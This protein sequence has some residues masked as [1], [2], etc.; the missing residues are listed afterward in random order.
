MKLR[1]IT[2]AIAAMLGLGPALM[3]SQQP[4]PA[5]PPTNTGGVPKKDGTGPKA[6]KGNGQGQ[7]NKARKGKKTGPRDGTGPIHPSPNGGRR[8]GRK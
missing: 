8:G 2:L 5:D 6:R 4:P 3:A 7:D 1:L